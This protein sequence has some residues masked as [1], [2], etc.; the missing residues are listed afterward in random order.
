M[1]AV[2]SVF[3]LLKREVVSQHDEEMGESSPEINISQ[4]DD[5]MGESSPEIDISQNDDE[6]E[7]KIDQVYKETVIP[8]IPSELF[9]DSTTSEFINACRFDQLFKER[10][11]RSPNYTD[12]EVFMKCDINNNKCIT[13]AQFDAMFINITI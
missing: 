13:Q 11:D 10:H 7:P 12:W 6:E 5:E 3:S 2:W 1:G 9:Q 8:S 4:H